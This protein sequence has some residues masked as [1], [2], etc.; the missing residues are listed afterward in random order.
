MIELLAPAGNAEK[1][2]CAFHFGADAVYLGGLKMGLRAQADNFD[3]AQMCDA[4]SYAH[5]LGK[6]IYVTVNIFAHNRDFSEL[7]EYLTFLQDID[8]DAIIV[9]DPGVIDFA[10]KV[11]PKLTLHLSTQANTTN[12]YSAKFW[13]EQGV[14]RLVLARELTLEEIK[15][16]RGFIP[17]NVEIEAFVHGAMCIS[18]SGRCLLSDFMTGRH[19]NLGACAQSCRWEYAIMEKTRDGEYFPIGED[20]RGT[21][22][23]NSKDLN[24]SAYI[25][26]L[27]DAGITSFKIEGR[28]KSSY[29]VAG[30]VNAYRRALDLY[31]STGNA[32]SLP[33]E[34]ERELEMLSHR[35]YGTGFYLGEKGSQCLETSKPEQKG[36][37]TAIVVDK[38]EDGV[39]VEMR[40]KFCVGDELEIMSPSD[41]NGK[42]LKVTDI[43]TE[44]GEK[45]Q[46][47]DKVQQKVILKTDLPVLPYDIL[48]RV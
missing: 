47:A 20:G 25:P 32:Y 35:M 31:Y 42:L 13:A 8:V 28:M 17:D 29:Y 19:S 16:I 33:R 24:M 5:A 12:K 11:A 9:S 46:I 45:L 38:T 18:Y 27:A 1:L 6:K 30:V 3:E 34:V 23:L 7:K 2:E 10:K 4:V 43:I 37:F 48:R 44:N 22:I 26:Q 14:K 36:V 15:E 41:V 40:N 39:V 21:Y